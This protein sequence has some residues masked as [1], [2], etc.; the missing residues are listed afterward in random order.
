MDGGSLQQG[1]AR[2]RC[3]VCIV[4]S[5]RFDV[6]APIKCK[7]S[8]RLKFAHQHEE[9]DA[10]ETYYSP[11]HGIALVKQLAHVSIGNVALISL[12]KDTHRKKKVKKDTH[13]H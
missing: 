10:L 3:V 11:A 8:Y 12:K 13:R 2:L 5:A 9:S 6:I 1:G 7:M 4:L